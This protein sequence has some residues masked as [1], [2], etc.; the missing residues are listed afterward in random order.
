MAKRSTN[1]AEETKY[2]AGDSPIGLTGAFA[3]VVQ[4]EDDS[5]F[6][7][8]PV[9]L[10]QAFGAVSEEDE[11]DG[12][13]SKWAGFDWDAPTEDAEDF[14]DELEGE[15]SALEQALDEAADTIDDA[16]DG[17][18][19]AIEEAWGDEGDAEEGEF[20]DDS[21][22][23]DDFDDFDDDD[24]DDDDMPRGRHAAHAKKPEEPEE[25]VSPTPKKSAWM[26]ERT[27]RSRHTR[28][29]LIIAILMLV[30][31]LAAGGIIAYNVLSEGQSKADQ[32]AHQQSA[33]EKT[34]IVNTDNNDAA[35]VAVKTADV[36]DIV[37]LL[38]KDQV[39]AV[40][41]LER[42]AT[43]T[44]TRDIKEE[45]NPIRHS[46]T[47][48]LTAE[49]ADSKTGTPN[50]Y[51]GLDRDGTVIQVG[52]SA[53]AATLGFGAVGF[54]DAVQKEHVIE[55]TMKDVGLADNIGT[56]ALPANKSE[57]S[58]YASDGTTLVRERCPFSGDVVIG[59][60]DCTWSSVLSY[61]YTTANL[62]GN[63][64][65]TVRVIYAYVTANVEYVPDPEPE[66]G[67]E[68]A[69]SQGAPAA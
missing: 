26:E 51:L 35:T 13:K 55:K 58:T 37:S 63:V 50:V 24:D 22:D 36:P 60:Q 28:R 15:E 6:Y 68:G 25:I 61:D 41:A 66:E 56:I 33:T 14:E 7:D 20:E 23:L 31:L 4:P 8:D 9:G 34:E 16:L 69:Q 52:Y 67:A 1:D 30:I 65:D 2:G 12:G 5:E 42:G 46:I 39:T 32:Q 62:T 21:D 19:D 64:N 40:N 29:S 44:S 43:I 54:A 47:I 27:R 11:W 17:V 45:G 53:S 48:A 18:E 49:P 10:T 38:G 3:P 59:G 57:Y